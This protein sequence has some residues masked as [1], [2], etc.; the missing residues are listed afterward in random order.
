MWGLIWG[1]WLPIFE[2]S[3]GYSV[4][5][6]VVVAVLIAVAWLILVLLDIYE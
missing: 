2:R 5:G 3:M 4:V 6:L 1:G